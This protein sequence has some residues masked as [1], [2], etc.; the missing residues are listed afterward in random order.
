MMKSKLKYDV[1]EDDQLTDKTLDNVAKFVRICTQN[2][3]AAQ[4]G[5]DFAMTS[6]P[7]NEKASFC[8]KVN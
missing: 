7:V 1:N 6:F 4:S 8:R 3:H 5:A 2:S